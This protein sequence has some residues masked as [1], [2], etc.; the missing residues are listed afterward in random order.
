[1]KFT[2]KLGFPQAIADAVKNDPYSPGD[3]DITATQ[4]ISPPQQV[5]L[6]KHCKDVIV[7]DVSDRVDSHA[8]RYHHGHGLG[9]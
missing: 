7:E 8:E 1:M 3:S 6:R 4:L 2:N 9:R 5:A